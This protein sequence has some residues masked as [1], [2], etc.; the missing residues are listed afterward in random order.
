VQHVRDN[1]VD[2]TL[3]ER[4]Y[5]SSLQLEEK[6][7]WP[8]E[9]VIDCTG[10]R[11]L[12]LSKALKEPFVS[13]SDYLLN[14]RAIP[15]Q[16]R[17][18]DP[19]RFSPITTCFAMDAG[20]AWHIP[21]RRHVGAGYVFCSRFKSEEQALGEFRRLLGA[22][23]EGLDP[24]PTIKLRVGRHERSWVKNCVAIG[25]SA[26]FMEPLESQAIMSIELALQWLLGYMPSTD[27]EEPLADQFNMCVN[28]LYDEVRDFIGLHYIL[29]QRKGPYWDAYRNEAKISDTLRGNLELW[30]YALPSPTDPGTRRIYNHWSLNSVLMGKNYYENSKLAGGGDRVPLQVWQQFCNH[31]NAAKQSMLARLASHND[32]LEHMYAQAA[33]GRSAIRKTDDPGLFSDV[34]LSTARPVMSDA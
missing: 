8:V 28:R 30:K 16:V 27:F 12:L 29:S 33:T 17:H 6:G 24:Q 32:L 2:V 7:E 11:G 5:I 21:L 15:M 31:N 10:F 13:F 4:G 14:D 25:L 26:G 22:E 34:L 20:W 23:A 3:D 19:R 9:L 1:L 18:R